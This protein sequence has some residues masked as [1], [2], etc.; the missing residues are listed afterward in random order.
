MTQQKTFTNLIP[1]KFSTAEAATDALPNWNDKNIAEITR[2]RQFVLT[3]VAELAG[4]KQAVFLRGCLRCF[5]NFWMWVLLSP[6]GLVA[7]IDKY[8]TPRP[9][10]CKGC[11]NY[12]GFVGRGTKLVCAIHPSGCD[13]DTCSDWNDKPRTPHT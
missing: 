9:E 13:G 5:K 1:R 4:V 10:A 6:N 8:R 12:S 2:D 3:I 7:I 11:T